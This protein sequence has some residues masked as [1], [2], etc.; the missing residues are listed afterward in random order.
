MK[1]LEIFLRSLLLRLLL[2]LTPGRAKVT[3][4]EIT[5]K[6]KILIIRLN[7]IGDALVT[8]PFI[9]V[10]SEIYHPQI[11]VLADTKNKFVFEKCPG[12][13]RV[14]TF[15]KGIGYFLKL[16]KD[17][18]KNEFDYVFDLHDD[19][20]TTVSLILSRI[21]VNNI[22]GFEKN[23]KKI[24]SHVVIKPDS[25]ITH[26]IDRSMALLNFSIRK[27][28]R[29]DINVHFEVSEK[30]N[31][32]IV[33]ML[34]EMF[35]AKKFLIGIN[36]SSGSK[37]RFWGVDRYQQLLS[38]I[39]YEKYEVILLSSPN[40]SELLNLI[41]VKKVD[42]FFTKD[43]EEFAAV[44][45]NLDLLFTPDTSV[46]HLASAYRIPVFGLYVKYQTNDVIWYPF[47]S[48]YQAVITEEPDFKNLSF[49]EVIN[50]FI[51]FL[52]KI[53]HAKRNTK[54]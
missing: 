13:T 16:I 20:S 47:K 1:S 38:S 22:I 31:N 48:E 7:R 9:K 23:T 36:I 21:K 8:T 52:E 40:D 3:P 26:V 35:P 45:K 5:E 49:N 19:V 28:G 51:P 42:T 12:V 30:R 2:I 10:L 43:F 50:K 6:S 32:N 15:E 33:G 39:D 11:T 25:T 41:S 54:V 24:Y 29:L 44:I 17:L 53:Y 34:Q 27:P 18:N 37:A 14:I 4:P 46:V